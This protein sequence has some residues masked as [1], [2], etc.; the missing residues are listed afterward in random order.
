MCPP[1]IH[2][3]VIE[4]E[5]AKFAR[6][7]PRALGDPSVFPLPGPSCA[8]AWGRSRG[9]WV[10]PA[11]PARI[12]THQA[13]AAGRLGLLI[14]AGRLPRRIAV[15]KAASPARRPGYVIAGA[16]HR[17]GEGWAGRREACTGLA[18]PRALGE[19]ASPGRYSETPRNCPRPRSP[20]SPSVGEGEDQYV[21]PCRTLGAP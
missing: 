4:A 19:G 16:E 5:N 20:L 12:H 15:T 10:P 11:S 7:I 2:G 21:M 18:A 13:S 9:A 17:L 8:R 14:L 6:Q 1:A 3:S